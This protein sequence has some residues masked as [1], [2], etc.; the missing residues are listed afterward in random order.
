MG[1]MDKGEDATVLPLVGW[2]VASSFL[3]PLRRWKTNQYWSLFLLQKPVLYARSLM[4]QKRWLF[5][6]GKVVSSVL[7]G[8][9]AAWKTLGNT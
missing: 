8:A 2:A 7:V 3:L 9:C 5:A 6:S 1:E 4:I